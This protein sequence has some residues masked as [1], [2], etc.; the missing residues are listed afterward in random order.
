MN[1]IY[2]LLVLLDQVKLLVRLI[3]ELVPD[4]RTSVIVEPPRGGGPITFIFRSVMF[5]DSLE[6]YSDKLVIFFI[7]YKIIFGQVT[8]L[9]PIKQVKN[10]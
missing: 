3:F 8:L 7:L 9:G 1:L 5:V 2:F 6:F 4:K 10:K